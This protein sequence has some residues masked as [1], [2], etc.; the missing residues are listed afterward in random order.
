MVGHLLT[1]QVV[2]LLPGLSCQTHQNLVQHSGLVDEGWVE[3]HVG[4]ADHVSLLAVVVDLLNKVKHALDQGVAEPEK[5]RDYPIIFENLFL[6][7][8][9]FMRV[10][11]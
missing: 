9:A 7:C 8:S 10:H 4:E 1:E 11:L 2:E 3:E 6:I 5:K